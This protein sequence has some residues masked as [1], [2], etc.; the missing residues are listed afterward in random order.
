MS[1][2]IHTIRL[3][4]ESL[5][6][7]APW[8]LLTAAVF[9]SIWATRRWLPK[10]WVLFDS[11]TPDGALSKV[12]QGLPAVLLG[13]VYTVTMSGGNFGKAWK[14]ALWGAL[15]PVVHEI[16]KR[17][18]GEVKAPASPP[19][20][21]TMMV[22]G[23]LLLL[24]T[25]CAGSLPEAQTAGAH[26]RAAKLGLKF[27]ATPNPT[28]YCSGL[29]ASHRFWGG[30]AKSSALLAGGAGL[31]TVPVDNKDAELGLAIG[32]AAMG[33]VAAAATYFAEDAASSFARDCGQ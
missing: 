9:A 5:D 6:P 24:L 7:A 26:D 8:L 2:L 16:A 19:K 13:A 30:V 29:D 12:L 14:G 11:V 20:S 4:L 31:A 22:G 17:Y 10:L 21:V 23:L 1:E 25:G 28:P 32:S 27:G 33:A 18:Q 15:A 3:F